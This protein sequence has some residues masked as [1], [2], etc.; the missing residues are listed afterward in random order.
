MRINDLMILFFFASPLA[1]IFRLVILIYEEYFAQSPF[2][3]SSSSLLFSPHHDEDGSSITN[4]QHSYLYKNSIMRNMR[5]AM[6]EASGTSNRTVNATQVEVSLMQLLNNNIST[7]EDMIQG[8]ISSSYKTPKFYASPAVSFIAQHSMQTIAKNMI[9]STNTVASPFKK[10]SSSFHMILSP[11]GISDVNYSS[12]M[13]KHMLHMDLQRVLPFAF[14]CFMLLWMPLFLMMIVPCCGGSTRTRSMAT[15]PAQRERTRDRN[16]KRIEIQKRIQV[17]L[18]RLDE[19][20]MVISFQDEACPQKPKC[21][22]VEQPQEQIEIVVN[23]PNS[24]YSMIGRRIFVSRDDCTCAICLTNYQE[25]QIV[26]Q[27][28]NEPCTHIFHH[29]CMKQ[30]IE[31]RAA[32][33]CPCCRRNFVQIDAYESKSMTI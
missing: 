6:M 28:T 3:S 5:T 32:S 12:F 27:S 14:T 17:L 13:E 21:V 22:V 16:K 4:I 26:V 11:H 9:P 7:I 1:S 10:S 18:E 23:E 33:D 8:M 31:K 24:S 2:E 29:Q 19:C 30:W 20:R 25:G 15:Y